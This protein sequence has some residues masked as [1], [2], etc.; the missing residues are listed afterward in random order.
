M[1]LILLLL[2]LTVAV[3][4]LAA[5][6]VLEINQTC[7]VETGCFSG[8]T[9]G[10][11][12]TITEAGSY[13]L[14]SNLRPPDLDTLAIGVDADD[15]TLDLGGFG[16]EF[17]GSG[18]LS[19]SICPQGAGDGIRGAGGGAGG[20]RVVV[21]NGYIR[22]AGR[23]GISLSDIATID[24]VRV[25]GCGEDGIVVGARSIV[26]KAHV[27]NCGRYGGQFGG[28]TVFSHSVFA[29]NS[30][31][32]SGGDRDGGIPTIG[33]VCG[34]GSCNPSPRRRRYYLTTSQYT[35]NAPLDAGVCAPG[36]HFASYAELANPTALEYDTSRGFTQDDSGSGPPAVPVAGGW[37]RSGTASESI[38]NC[39]V[40]TSAS[41]S[42]GGSLLFLLQTGALD[43]TA[44]KSDPWRAGIAQCDVPLAV[45]CVED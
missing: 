16:I 39:N 21:T 2:F 19:Q 24:T 22:N 17:P 29:F 25:H 38:Q 7:A 14:T 45:W 11:P 28:N 4:A 15:V 27:S 3:P 30:L 6:G 32:G 23:R 35:G 41:S 42:H 10:F 5:D 26:T 18:C 37:V 43:G 20:R 9:P 36:F 1:R 44:S 34:D 13:R 12:V 8:D 31:Q 33:N 40:W